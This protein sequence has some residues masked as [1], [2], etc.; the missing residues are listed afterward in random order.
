VIDAPIE[1]VYAVASDP[2][3][4]PKYA[5][6]IVRITHRAGFARSGRGATRFVQ[7][8]IRVCGFT[9][10]FDYRYRFVPPT[11]YSGVQIGRALVRGFFWMRFKSIDD[12]AATEVQHVEGI[13][14]RIP[15]L[16]RFAGWIWFRLLAPDGPGDELRGLQQLIESARA[17][18]ALGCV[19]GAAPH[20]PSPREGRG[21]G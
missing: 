4:V 6:E 12:G 3:M 16:A 21:Q 1:R 19:C 18:S 13:T 7:S 20:T 14:S 8:H 2:Q 17:T 5:G 9:I 10:P 11:H 15:L